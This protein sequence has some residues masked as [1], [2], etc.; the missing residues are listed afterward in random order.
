MAGKKRLK[1]L[2]EHEQVEMTEL[3]A[4]PV[5]LHNATRSLQDA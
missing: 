4:K 2:N 5:S 3:V 1:N